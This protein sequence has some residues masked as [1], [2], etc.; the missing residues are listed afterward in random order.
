MYTV[1]AALFLVLNSGISSSLPSNVVPLMMQEFNVTGDS[2][3]VL[4]TAMFLI[5]YVVGP[6]VFSPLSEM[7]GRKSVLLWSFTVFV[8]ATLGCAFAPN[9]PAML[10]FR[11][12]CGAMGSAP[13][14]VV[15]GVYADMFSTPRA[16]GRVMTF[17]MAVC[18][19]TVH[20]SWESC[21]TVTQ[22]ASFG[23]IIGP[24][25]SGCSSQY[26]WRWTF[27]IDLILTGCSLL[28]SLFMPGV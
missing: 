28:G 24:I 25:I 8:L 11:F 17:Y 6:L 10:I 22:A 3:K 7:I 14:T 21:L 26:G 15:G 2:Q 20:V 16:R 19:P 27:R 1:L 23:P 12:I 9:W 13:Q 18:C 5:G 4:P